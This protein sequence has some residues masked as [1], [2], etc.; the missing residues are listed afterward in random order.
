MG[1]FDTPS[2]FG[3]RLK[4]KPGGRELEGGGSDL[5]LKGEG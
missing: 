4:A 5:S 1:S 2:P 3:L